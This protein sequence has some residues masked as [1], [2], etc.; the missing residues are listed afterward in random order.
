MSKRMIILCGPPGCG[1]S[2]RCRELVKQAVPDIDPDDLDRVTITGR[3][4]NYKVE[5]KVRVC[6]ADHHFTSS[7]GRYEFKAEDL[8]LAHFMCQLHAYDA[9]ECRCPLVIVDNTNMTARE[10]AIYECLA[11]KFGYELVYEVLGEPE[12]WDA[13]ELARRNTHGVPEEVIKRRIAAY[14]PPVLT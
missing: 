3:N 10:R 5:N 6:S 2:T 4:V 1:K 13:A 7:V 14:E 9:C 11:R 12:N 8:P